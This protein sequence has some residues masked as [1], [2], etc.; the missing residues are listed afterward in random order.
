MLDLLGS[1]QVPHYPRKLD[2]VADEF[3]EAVDH[4]HRIDC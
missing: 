1:Y 4:S 3:T 2:R